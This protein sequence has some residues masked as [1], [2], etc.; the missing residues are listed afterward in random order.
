MQEMKQL[1]PGD[2]VLV[3]GCS[4]EPYLCA[5]KDEA[6]L[7]NSFQKHVHMPLP[8]YASRQI[9]WPAL[10]A[11]HGAPVDTEFDWPTL[12]QISQN[13]TSG[14]IDQVVQSMLTAPR[15][16]RLKLGTPA[17]ALQMSEFINWLALVEPVAAEADAQ[18]RAFAEKTPARAALAV[19]DAKATGKKPG[20][21]GGKKKKK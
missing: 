18:I 20:S 8:D 4:S 16:E 2:R 14:Q 9:I 5:K 21:K 15:L 6:A 3:V 13:Y 10:C 1:K 19:G 17:N 11:K 7:L 12:A